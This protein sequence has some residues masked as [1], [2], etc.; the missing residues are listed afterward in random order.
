MKTLTN[1][2]IPFKITKS[3]NDALLVQVDEGPYFYDQLHYHPEIQITA[4]VK[5]EGVI[6]AGNSM[7]SFAHNS[8]ILIGSCVPHLFRNASPSIEEDTGCRLISLFFDQDSFGDRFFGVTE[9]SGIK[10][11]LENSNRGII[12]TGSDGEE[13]HDIICSSVDHSGEDL[14]ITMLQ[15][16]SKIRVADKQ[17]INTEL[18]QL[19]LNENEGGRLSDVLYYTFEHY[20]KELKIEQIAQIANLSRSQFST[21]FKLHTNKTY[22]QFLNEVRIENACRLL[23]EPRYTVEQAAYEVGFKNMSNFARQFRKV[24]GSTASAYRKQWTQVLK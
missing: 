15:V 12:I 17:Y 16:L 9:M 21:F 22:I 5:G 8:V 19:K 18:Y 1:K 20:A 11:L 24:K 14:I 10:G 2:A 3:A 4:I 6:Y 13:I 23:K 7:T